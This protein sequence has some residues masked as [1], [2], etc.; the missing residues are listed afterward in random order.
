MNNSRRKRLGQHFLV[1]PGIID[2]IIT[3][4][5]PL[6]SD[7]MVEIGPGHGALTVKLADK[8]A[9]LDI[10]EIDSHLVQE[11]NY[12]FQSRN[13]RIHQTSALKFEYEKVQF[14]NRKIRI[15][16]NLPYSIST[17]LLIKLLDYAKIVDN[18]IFMLQQEVADRLTAERGT[19]AYGR[20]TVVVGRCFEVEKV[21]SVSPEAFAPPP[22]VQ[23]CVIYMRPKPSCIDAK[24]SENFSHLVRAAF[25]NR[26]KTLKNALS[27]LIVASEVEESG[28][29]FTR[30]PEDL[31]IEEYLKLA[32][33][34]MKKS[35]QNTKAQSQTRG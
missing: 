30:R 11:L 20:L 14:E 35:T 26:R 28:I 7:N 1:S 33:C 21:F 22:K 32:N 34:S 15:V 19:K 25:I 6:P 13:V 2:E 31:S 23:S 17:P 24:T 9:T 12:K 10:V 29:D 4:I 27:G 3:L 18:M 5:R 8:T 16:G